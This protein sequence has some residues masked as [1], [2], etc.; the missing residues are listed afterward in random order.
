MS[1]K[2]SVSSEFA[3]V[4]SPVSPEPFSRVGT[5]VWLLQC[6]SRPVY[7]IE[8]DDDNIVARHQAEGF[9]T[10]PFT[11]RESCSVSLSALPNRIIADESFKV[12]PRV[13]ANYVA[14]DYS[15]F[16]CCRTNCPTNPV[17]SLYSHYLDIVDSHL[18]DCC[19]GHW[20]EP[21]RVPLAAR[22]CGQIWP[23]YNFEA[24]SLKIPTSVVAFAVRWYM[25]RSINCG[26]DSTDFVVSLEK[27]PK[28]VRSAAGTDYLSDAEIKVCDIVSRGPLDIIRDSSVSTPASAVNMYRHIHAS[29]TTDK[30]DRKSTAVDKDILLSS[31]LTNGIHHISVKETSAELNSA[32]NYGLQ[33]NFRMFY[34]WIVGYP[35][36]VAFI[37]LSEGEKIEI[38]AFLCSSLSELV[39]DGLICDLMSAYHTGSVSLFPNPEWLAIWKSYPKD[40]AKFT[41]VAR[42]DLVYLSMHVRSQTGSSVRLAFC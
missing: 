39:D 7:A 13:V 16:H 35:D 40:T 10:V 8:S 23:Q 32:I 31:G 14:N 36:P 21:N 12:V 18:Y 29:F 17:D 11:S 24:S 5:D 9:S 42:N 3:P 38:A 19:V 41:R 1:S 30:R 26:P 4:S 25:L 15:L 34:E 37:E 22:V 27:G 20:F 2:L 33:L 28:T 6:G